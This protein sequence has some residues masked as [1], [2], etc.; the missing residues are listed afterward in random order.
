[1]LLYLPAHPFAASDVQPAEQQD[2]DGVDDVGAPAQGHVKAE[3]ENDP[4]DVGRVDGQAAQFQ[5]EGGAGVARAGHG[6][7]VDIGGNQYQVG[8]THDPQRRDGRLAQ[9]WHIGIDAQDEVGED[10]EQYGQGQ[11]KE[12]GQ[13]RMLADEPRHLVRVAP[14]DEIA[15]QRAARRGEGHH[16]HEEDARGAAHDVGHGQG[17]FAQV[18]DVEEEQEPRPQGEEVLYHRPKGHVQHAAEHIRAE[19]G[20]AVQPIFPDVYAPAGIED[21]EHERYAFG[22]RGADGGAR[23]AQGRE[24]QVAE[25]QDVVEHH[26]AQHHHDGVEGQRLG[27]HRAQEEGA[28]DDGA[29]REERAEHPPVQVVL[30][31]AAHGG[32]GDDVFQ[33]QGRQEVAEQEHHCGQAHLEVDAVVEQL[34]DGLVVFLAIAPGDEYLRTDAEPEGHH[35]DD[36]VEDAGNG[37]CAQFDFAHAAQEGGVRHAD[38]LFHDE[39]DEDGVGDVP[40]LAVGVLCLLH[41]VS[42]P[43][44]VVNDVYIKMTPC[45]RYIT[46]GGM[47]YY[48]SGNGILPLWERY[49]TLPGMV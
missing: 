37:R 7:E 2:E 35:E 29:E 11:H 46:L 25:Y 34:A 33:Y 18:L 45:E 17:P 36:H 22:Q 1:M 48:P 9:V 49:I 23:D 39:A 14:A 26:V 13:A 20:D 30:G 38:H 5:H 41:S 12:V 28:E 21:E 27:L 40:D 6:L 3:E 42:C 31:S 32:R 8:G 16:H 15:G 24:A 10:G 44:L 19:A 4:G 43:C 47:V